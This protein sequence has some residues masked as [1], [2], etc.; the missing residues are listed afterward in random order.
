MAHTIKMIIKKG[1]TQTPLRD[2]DGAPDGGR[3]EISD[4][5]GPHCGLYNKMLPVLH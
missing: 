4:F 2:P 5:L 3:F 1:H